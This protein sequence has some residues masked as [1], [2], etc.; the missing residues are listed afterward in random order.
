MTLNYE[1][2]ETAYFWS[3]QVINNIILT[4]LSQIASPWEPRMYTILELQMSNVC[5]MEFYNVLGK[6]DSFMQ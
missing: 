4:S 5:R 2:N 1:W 3:M 6:L